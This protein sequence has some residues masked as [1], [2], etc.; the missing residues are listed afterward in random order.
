M[1]HLF[2]LNW[3]CEGAVIKRLSQ[4]VHTHTPRDLV[5]P[6]LKCANVLPNKGN[7]VSLLL[8][9]GS[10]EINQSWAKNQHVHRSFVTSVET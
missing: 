9:S 5:R 3:H 8:V 2:I 10:N 6:P 7:N 4:K 1:D